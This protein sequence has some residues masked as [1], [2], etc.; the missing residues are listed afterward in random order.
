MKCDDATNR[1][2][3]GRY[4]NFGRKYRKEILHSE[5]IFSSDRRKQHNL[6]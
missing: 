2:G 4:R 1:H 3:R 6:Q 5:Y